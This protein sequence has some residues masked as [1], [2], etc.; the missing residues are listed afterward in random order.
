MNAR[1]LFVATIGTLMGL[2]GIEHGIGEVL[3]ENGA[4]HSLMI[5]SWPDSAFF[6]SLNGE[7]AMTILP[8]LHITGI[9]AVLFSLLFAGGAIFFAQRKHSGQVLILLAVL[10]LLFG[11]GIFPPI[12]GALV[13]AAATGL[14]PKA[15]GQPITS[16]GRQLGSAWRWIFA[17]CCLAWLALF[18]GVAVMGYFFGVDDVHVTLAVMMAAIVLLFLAYWSGIQ[19]DRI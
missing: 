18:P 4:Q 5:Q 13:G 1:H 2:A 11:G 15:T 16:L 9:L 7:P 19:H 12:L 10:M 3:Q 17:A 6:H 14:Q 8:D